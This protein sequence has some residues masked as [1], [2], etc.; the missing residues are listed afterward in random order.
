MRFVSGMHAAQNPAYRLARHSCFFSVTYESS[1]Q[2]CDAG[3]S[4]SSRRRQH[5][6]APSFEV[7]CGPTGLRQ[8]LVHGGRNL[9]Y[10]TCIFFALYV[11]ASVLHATEHQNGQQLSTSE[12]QQVSKQGTQSPEAY[13]LYLTGRSYWDKQ[14]R[15][16]LETA[17]SYFNQAIAKDPGYAL[18]YA[19]LA[20]AYAILPDYGASPSEDIPKSKA[21]ARKAIELDA[22]LARPHV[23]LGGIKMAHEWDFAGG[24]AEFKKAL[25]LDPNDAHAHQRYADN[26]GLLAGREQEALAEINRAHELDPLSPDVDVEVGIVYTDA[27]RFDKAIAVCKNVA[28]ENPTFATAHSCL[29]TAY[30]G[31]HMYA[32]V[33]EEQKVYGQLSG[34]RNSSEYA[35]AMENGFRSGGWQGALTKGLEALQAQR[36][37]GDSS[38]YDIAAMYAQLGDKEQAFLWLNTAFQEHDE[39]LM[40]LK[41][42]FTLDSLRSDPRFAEMVRKVGLPR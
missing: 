19:G 40:W 10:F 30:W 21:A 17:V 6:V 7:E 41:I 26:L 28:N 23:D 22:T 11:C 42:D 9:R 34:D 15:A 4:Q 5:F 20:D 1:T 18:A 25:E 32:Q 13:A 3:V 12:K 36:K 37:T 33:I 27:R 39:H 16:D 35:L 38:A 29:A 2:D 31:K 24:E 8:P 14:T